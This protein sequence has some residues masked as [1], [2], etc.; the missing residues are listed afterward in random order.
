M[1]KKLIDFFLEVG[2]I[3]R[4]KQRGFLLR[5]IKNPTTIGGHSFREAIMAWTLIRVENAGLD[6]SR[7]IKIVLVHD[8]CAGYAGDITP[9]E[10]NLNKNG[11]KAFEKWI[12]LPKKEKERLSK[13]QR[14]KEREALKKLT[15][16]LPRSLA[17]EMK[18]LWTEYEQGL[19]AEGRFVQQIDMLENFLQA[20]E[21]WK[22]DKKFPIESWWQQMKE[23]I[24]NPALVE[25]LKSLDKEFYQK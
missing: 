4:Q 13:Q 2:K 1:D 23:L 8:L 5:G 24:S 15:K 9:Y 16:N 21:Y 20:L 7:I 19:T 14:A 10:S 3:K 6:S 18:H 11:K 12:R 17:S 22:Q 25:L